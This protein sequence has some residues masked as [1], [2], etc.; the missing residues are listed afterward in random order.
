M[1]ERERKRR[2]RDHSL[3]E[4]PSKPKGIRRPS[5]GGVGKAN[6]DNPGD[7]DQSPTSKTRF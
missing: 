5:E 4:S 2:R 1:T 3:N 6:T 7:P